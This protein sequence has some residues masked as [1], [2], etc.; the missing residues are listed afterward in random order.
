MNKDISNYLK[1]SSFLDI[2]QDKKRKEILYYWGAGVPLNFWDMMH[3]AASIFPSYMKRFAKHILSI[4][5]T[6]ILKHLHI[7]DVSR[8]VGIKNQKAYNFPHKK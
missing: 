5:K 6:L 1:D 8:S 3:I 7:F 2:L 4:I